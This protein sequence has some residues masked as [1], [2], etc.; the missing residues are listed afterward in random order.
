MDDKNKI[1][2]MFDTL[3][4]KYDFMNNIIS[5]GLHKIIKKICIKKINASGNALDLCCGTGDISKL[6]NENKNITN[7]IGFDF[8]QSMIDIANLKNK[9]S[10]ITYQKGDCT[11]LPF[12]DNSLDIC[13]ISFGLRNI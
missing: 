10:K 3:A 11:Q 4:P 7:V 12:D 8:S 6:L 9:T 5:F 2:N 1:Q 13:T